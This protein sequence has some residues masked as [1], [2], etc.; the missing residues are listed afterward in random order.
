MEQVFDVVNTVLK[1]DKETKRR[2]LNIRRYTVMPLAEQA[3]ILEF[4]ENSTPLAVWLSGAH[5]RYHP[6]CY[7][8]QFVF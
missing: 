5:A 7:P 3:G 2:N 4:V 8:A 6:L 1:C